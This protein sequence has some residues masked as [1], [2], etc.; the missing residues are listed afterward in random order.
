MTTTT[1]TPPTTHVTFG[2]RLIDLTD[3]DP[4]AEA[5][6]RELAETGMPLGWRDLR[7]CWRGVTH[8]RRI[9]L[10]RRLEAENRVSLDWDAFGLRPVIIS[11]AL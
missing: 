7:H 3:D 11:M 4:V 9:M 6:L 10:L 5:V 1:S 2:G 8:P